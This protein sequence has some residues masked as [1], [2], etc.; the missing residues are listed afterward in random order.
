MDEFKRNVAKS[1]REV[2]IVIALSIAPS[3]FIG[4]LI[5]GYSH[6]QSED[7]VVESYLERCGPEIALAIEAYKIDN[8]G[9]PDS[10]TNAACRTISKVPKGSCSF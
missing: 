6:F 2:R 9:Y 1:K 5:A 4:L 3:T 7:K 8:G 10:I